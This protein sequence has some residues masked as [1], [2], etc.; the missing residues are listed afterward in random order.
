MHG[1]NYLYGRGKVQGQIIFKGK[2]L[3]TQV[4]VIDTPT[5]RHLHF[6]TPIIQSSMFH[7]DPYALEMEY[8]QVMMLALLCHPHPTSALF[9]GLGGGS[10]PKFLWRYFPALH[11]HSVEISPLV[12]ET[13]QTYFYLPQDERF[14]VQ[15]C[16][17][18]HYLTNALECFDLLFVD[19]YLSDRM[20]SAP[21]EPHFFSRC[22]D[23]L[24]Q[25]G[26]LIW[27]LWSSTPHAMITKALNHLETL[28]EEVLLFKVEESPNLI[29]ICK[30]RNFL[31]QKELER[32][33]VK[34]TAQTGMDFTTLT[35]KKLCFGSL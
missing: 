7:Q 9:L 17:A 12:I 4:E 15:C 20:A 34:L 16:S 22:K 2:D 18:E 27:N 3:Y 5:L 31:S 13:A 28:F 10:K 26:I 29:L 1:S 24:N 33:A 25:G 11:C 35:R 8:N 14:T 21:G 23:R 32:Q 30:D 19:L 6:G